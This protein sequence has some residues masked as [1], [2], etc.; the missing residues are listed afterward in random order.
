MSHVFHDR[1]DGLSHCK[2]CNGAEGS[3]TTDCPGRKMPAE[4]EEAVYTGLIDYAD[5]AWR[6][7]V[8]QRMFALGIPQCMLGDP[9]M[10]DDAVLLAFLAD[11]GFRELETDT[12]VVCYS[13]ECP[14]KFV[15][16]RRLSDG[17]HAYVRGDGQPN[18]YAWVEVTRPKEVC[19]GPGRW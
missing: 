11:S 5:G 16:Y 8:G 1:G 15:L 4:T 7:G 19:H 10:F 17:R 13:N 18:G 14:S 3:L 6:P 9:K 12:V 2:I